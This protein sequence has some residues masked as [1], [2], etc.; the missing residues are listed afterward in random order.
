MKALTF[1]CLEAQLEIAARPPLIPLSVV[2]AKYEQL[3]LPETYNFLALSLEPTGGSAFTGYCSE[4]VL[5]SCIG[6]ACSRGKES[7]PKAVHTGVRFRE[8]VRTVAK[9]RMPLV[10]LSSYTVRTCSKPSSIIRL[11]RVRN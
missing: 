9:S 4:L 6:D 11:Y 1:F 10:D 2:R 7:V 3:N 5:G 8:P